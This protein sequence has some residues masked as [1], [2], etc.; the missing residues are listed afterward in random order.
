MNKRGRRDNLTRKEVPSIVITKELL[1]ELSTILENSTASNKD[2]RSSFKIVGRNNEVIIRNNSLDFLKY[3]S[4]KVKAIE[5]ASDCETKNIKI[6]IDFA[7]PSLSQFIIRGTE[8]N[9]VNE[10]TENFEQLFKHNKRGN[11]FH[12]G[13]IKPLIVYSCLALIIS[14]FVSAFLSNNILVITSLENVRLYG[15]V[16]GVV[17]A[18]S[19][20]GF[21]IL[22]KRLHRKYII[23]NPV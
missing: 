19:L 13:I 4:D 12:C 7:E 23:K 17:I 3:Y 1:G 5:M 2:S 14:Y 9:W 15:M 6:R 11:E 10:T 22:F 21:H 18:P 20:I 8:P 16:F